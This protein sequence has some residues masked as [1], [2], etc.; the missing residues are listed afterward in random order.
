MD[1]VGARLAVIPPVVRDAKVQMGHIALIVRPR[2]LAFALNVKEAAG[3]LHLDALQ[4]AA[5]GVLESQAPM[6]KTVL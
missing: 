5:R 2:T 4:L 1:V 3:D 6:P